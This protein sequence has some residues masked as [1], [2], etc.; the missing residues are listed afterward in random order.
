MKQNIQARV[1][2]IINCTKEHNKTKD[3]AMQTYLL[4]CKI[5]RKMHRKIKETQLQTHSQSDISCYCNRTQA[6]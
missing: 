3:K 1:T 6:A 5:L 2:M 4:K